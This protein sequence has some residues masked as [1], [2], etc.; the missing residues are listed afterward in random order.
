MRHIDPYLRVPLLNHS[1]VRQS[2]SAPWRDGFGNLPFRSSRGV[3]GAFMTLQASALNRR[4]LPW[5]LGAFRRPLSNHRI[6]PV[7]STRTILP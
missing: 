3:G 4:P 7:R 5:F 6:A 1:G 2:K